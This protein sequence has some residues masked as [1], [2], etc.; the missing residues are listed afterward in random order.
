MTERRT[1]CLCSGTD[2]VQFGMCRPC[3][4]RLAMESDRAKWARHRADDERERG[5]VAAAI[6]APEVP[7]PFVPLADTEDS[8]FRPLST[9][10]WLTE[11]L[12]IEGTARRRRRIVVLVLTIILLTVLVVGATLLVTARK[13]SLTTT[14]TVP[15]PTHIEGSQ[16]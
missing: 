3:R 9:D 6:V 12:L 13:T 8:L 15:T 16:R 11:G 1:C 2:D 5:D 10:T 4:F 7:P 14:T